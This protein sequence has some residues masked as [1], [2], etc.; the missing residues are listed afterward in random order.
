MPVAYFS[1]LANTPSETARQVMAG[2]NSQLGNRPPEGAIFHAE[3]PTD[4][5]GWWA[6]NVWESD[7]AAQQF[8]ENILNPVLKDLNIQ[9]SGEQKLSVVWE[10]N[11]P[12]SRP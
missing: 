2:V 3:G 4:D 8:S 12:E 9:M 6:F 11:H 5:G 10:S 1:R 7:A